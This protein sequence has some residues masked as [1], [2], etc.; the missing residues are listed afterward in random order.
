MATALI[1]DDSMFIR[2]SIRK[3]LEEMNFNKI[4][5]AR[6]GL[7]AVAKTELFQPDLVLLDVIMPKMDG[8]TALVKIMT[9]TPTR[10]LVM[11]AYDPTHANIAFQALEHG[12]LDFLPKPSAEQAHNYSFD[13]E[14]RKK[15][16]S[17]L[18]ARL[19]GHKHGLKKILPRCP[20]VQIKNRF[21]IQSRSL[22]NSLI[23]VGASTGGP[24]VVK[25]ILSTLKRPLPPIIL[26]QHL[27]TGFSPS[28]AA[29]LSSITDLRVV[30]AS[31]G[32]PL[33]LNTVYVAPGGKHLVFEEK[34]NFIHTHLFE[35]DPVNGVQPSL[36]PTIVSASYFYNNR[37]IVI[38]LTGMGNDGLAG[39]RYA[40]ENGAF[41]IAQDKSSS[42]IYGMPKAVIDANLA[43]Y[44]ANPTQISTF[45]NNFSN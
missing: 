27:T 11:S 26:L 16:T 38:I 24:T 45:L 14:L 36:D 28:F 17:C 19:N 21:H 44:I 12:A 39:T 34:E 6:D 8:L 9:K 7:D 20:K 42:S 33:E 2:K 1:A 13:H 15:I 40:S 10:V 41:V 43:D 3:V 35:S 23:I 37:L 30:E 18:Q 29:R 22:S 4:C 25:K 5:E 32:M 31:V